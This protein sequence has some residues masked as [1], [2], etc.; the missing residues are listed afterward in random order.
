[1]ITIDTLNII[2]DDVGCFIHQSQSSYLVV[3]VL[4]VVGVTVRIAG[5]R[6]AGVGDVSYIVRMSGSEGISNRQSNS[7]LVGSVGGSLSLSFAVVMVEARSSIVVLS[8]VA[9]SSVASD[10]AV[11]VVNTG[12]DASMGQTM[13]HLPKGVGISLSLALD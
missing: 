6:V 11:A 8:S 4:V 9:E 5:G 2:I 1:M 12:D 13:G 10:Q 3:V 7:H